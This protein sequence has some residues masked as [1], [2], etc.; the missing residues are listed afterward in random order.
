M[1]TKTDRGLKDLR[2]TIKH[3]LS[4]SKLMDSVMGQLSSEGLS[5]TG[6]SSS[7]GQKSY[8]V[9]LQ[10]L[11][12]DGVLNHVLEEL[13]KKMTGRGKSIIGGYEVSKAA[14]R[15][16]EHKDMLDPNRRYMIAKAYK[17]SGFADYIEPR[18][19]EYLTL[20][21][22]YLNQRYSSS[23]VTCSTD[24]LFDL[25]VHF[26]IPEAYDTHAMLRNNEPLILVLQKERENERPIVLST[27]LV[28]WRELLSHN[29]VDINIGRS[30][31]I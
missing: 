11:K 27:S 19:D 31:W 28:D 3:H 30:S 8:D 24:P 9:V 22:S 16:S 26:E 7:K 1:E 17:G 12:D 15:Y 13:Q 2:E 4:N 29:S 23:P 5:K 25:T 18:S 6:K 20:S 14:T 21:I 10:K